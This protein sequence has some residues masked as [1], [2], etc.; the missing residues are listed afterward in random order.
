MFNL[1][2]KRSLIGKYGANP[3]IKSGG[4]H[5]YVGE[6]EKPYRDEPPPKAKRSRWRSKADDANK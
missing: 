2:N 1:E 5:A 6:A 4:F 3:F